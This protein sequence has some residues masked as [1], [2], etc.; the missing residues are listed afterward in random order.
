MFILQP[1]PILYSVAQGM[2][3][4][5][6]R[7]KNEPFLALIANR[8]KNGLDQGQKWAIFVPGCSEPFSAIGQGQ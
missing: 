6:I 5:M 4:N 8:A 7:A 1:Y 3:I 2:E